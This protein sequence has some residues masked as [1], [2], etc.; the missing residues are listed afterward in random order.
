M[1][2]GICACGCGLPTRIPKSSNPRYGWVKG[3]PVRFRSGHNSR[4]KPSGPYPGKGIGHGK[5]EGIHRL[6]AMKALGRRLPKGAV[7][8]HTDGSKNPDAPLVICENHAYHML[9]HHRMRIKARGGN[10]NTDR[11]CSRCRNV[12]DRSDFNRFKLGFGGLSHYCRGCANEMNKEWR[13]KR[14]LSIPA[15]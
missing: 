7:V 11:I 4:L 14:C 9:L 1:P 15:F 3:F 8:H 13:N 5:A 10:P 12:K 6:R 2:I